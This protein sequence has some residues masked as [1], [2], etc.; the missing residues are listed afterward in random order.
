MRDDAKQSLGLCWSSHTKPG[1][2]LSCGQS[3]MCLCMTV[4][5]TCFSYMYFSG[6]AEA[7][8][9]MPGVGTMQ[10]QS[11]TRMDKMV[12][13]AVCC[14][15]SAAL[16]AD[17]RCPKAM[18]AWSPA[19]AVQ[20]QAS[21]YSAPQLHSAARSHETATGRHDGSRELSRPRQVG[22]KST[23]LPGVVAASRRL[24]G[25]GRARGMR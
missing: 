13:L 24:G 19:A 17:L 15:V 16:S 9:A 3:R 11:V 10:S 5:R 2:A 21:S 23:W 14:A 6:C 4:A 22:A 18:Q 8:P 7:M 20:S 12:I 1:C 25:T